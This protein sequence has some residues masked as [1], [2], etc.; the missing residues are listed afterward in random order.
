M[1]HF[2]EQIEVL[3][4]L[5]EPVYI[6]IGQFEVNQRKPPFHGLLKS[7]EFGIFFRTMVSG[8]TKHH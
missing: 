8:D 3:L 6:C 5:A 1:K 2:T 4:R 7:V